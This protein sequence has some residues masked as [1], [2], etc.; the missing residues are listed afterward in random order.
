MNARCTTQELT[1]GLPCP[2]WPPEGRGLELQVLERCSMS[3]EGRTLRWN[4]NDWKSFNQK[5]IWPLIVYSYDGSNDLSTG[6]CFYPQN[7]QW[8]PIT[9]MGTKRSCLGTAAYDGLVYCC[10]GYDGAS[11]L[12]SVERYDPLTGVWTSCPAMLT[13]R[14][15]CR[16][17]IMGEQKD[18]MPLLTKAIRHQ[19]LMN[20]LMKC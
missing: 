16:A 1:D 11:C 20:C 19:S 15:Y 17:V 13:K 12:S 10:G 6:E 9:P 3:W 14:R 8:S 5:T 18:K 7:N 4:R 2:R